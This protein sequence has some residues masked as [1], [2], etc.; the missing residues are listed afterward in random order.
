MAHLRSSL[1]GNAAGTIDGFDLS[2]EAFDGAWQ[3]VCEK[4]GSPELR[5]VAIY[6]RLV[7]L[8]CPDDDP[9]DVSRFLNQVVGL[10]AQAKRVGL[11]Q[12]QR[13]I[14]QAIEKALPSWMKP[15]LFSA[16]LAAALWNTD[17]LMA[18]LPRLV[19]LAPAKP[20][21]LGRPPVSATT[22]L[23]SHVENVGGT[24]TK[25]PNRPTPQ[26][27]CFL[28]STP[29]DPQLHRAPTM[30]WCAT[31]T[32][33]RPRSPPVPSSPR[34]CAAPVAN[35]EEIIPEATTAVASQPAAQAPTSLLLVQVPVRNPLTGQQV[36]V[37]AILDSGA[38]RCYATNQLKT[39][40]GLTE[41]PPCAIAVNTFGGQ[42]LQRTY[43]TISLTVVLDDGLLDVETLCTPIIVAPIFTRV[44]RPNH[45]PRLS[46][47]VPKTV[48]PSLLLG[49]P[50]FGVS[51]VLATKI[52]A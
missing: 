49:G 34:P 16:R 20:V 51:S 19:E 7:G 52:T 38:N 3:Y 43:G 29:E 32:P 24:P 33:L 36:T 13:A 22:T 48:Q 44:L 35:A 1:I 10:L 28:C 5:K 2:N 15:Y 18:H 41:S 23:S 14:Q 25:G 45:P 31:G 42:T 37:W 9:R 17:A 39:S 26:L 30:T 4:F 21:A 27:P 12:N 11:D 40:L 8:R 6:D 46:S 50:A 47:L